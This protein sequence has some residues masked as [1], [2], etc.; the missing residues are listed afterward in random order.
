MKVKPVAESAKNEATNPSPTD[1]E[2]EWEVEESLNTIDPPEPDTLII[3]P[4]TDDEDILRAVATAPSQ[5]AYG[6]IVKGTKPAKRRAARVG[7]NKDTSNATAIAIGAEAQLASR[8]LSSAEL[9]QLE[10]DTGMC[11]VL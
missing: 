11:W 4:V 2:D 3:T 1:Q 10:K 8:W 6:G 9:R 5:P 7:G